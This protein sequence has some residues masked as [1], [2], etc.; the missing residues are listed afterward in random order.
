ML[1]S[2]VRR[3][4]NE[5][6]LIALGAED[7]NY[8]IM[9]T[10]LPSPRAGALLEKF[11]I[12]LG[13]IFTAG[14]TFAPRVRHISPHFV[15]D[16]YEQ[17][18]MWIDTKYVVLWD[19]ETKRGWLVNG[20]SALLHLVRMS[21][22]LYKKDYPDELLFDERMMQNAPERDAV[23]ARRVLKH[24]RNRRLEV[25]RGKSEN[26]EETDQNI[27][28]DGEISASRKRKS[29]RYLF[30]HLVEQKYGVLELLME[31]HKQLA[32]S[33][34]INLK[35]RMR[36]HLEG[37]N[38]E[39]LASERDPEPRIATLQA[40]GYGWV[41]F[42]HSLKAITLFGRGF[43]EIFRPSESERICSQWLRLPKGEYYL[44]TSLSDLNNIMRRS[45]ERQ[46]EDTE[47][48]RGLLWHSP[49]DPFTPCR[50][51][52]HGNIR[53]SG[54][55]CTENHNP[56]QA[57]FPKGL[58][59][60][61]MLFP[62]PRKPENLNDSGAVIFG[63]T[64]SWRSAHGLNETEYVTS[65]RRS[66]PYPSNP[67]KRVPDLDLPMTS[68]SLDQS[69]SDPPTS[70]YGNVASALR[71]VET[72]APTP[73]KSTS[74]HAGRSPLIRPNYL[75]DTSEEDGEEYDDD[76][77]K[78]WWETG[79]LSR[80]GPRKDAEAEAPNKRIRKV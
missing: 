55:L 34:G 20:T 41:D 5:T 63:H 45:G 31:S 18:L 12:N 47:V 51:L 7:A 24:S 9:G 23:S 46:G 21:L 38:F 13:K 50:C 64:M 60:G 78:M 30:E 6:L 56:V 77:G 53:T 2:M 62:R 75:T 70:T 36:K 44:A 73:E 58:I 8:D 57:F 19:E 39:D 33:N 42:A 79:Q 27:A 40:L 29:S 69:S 74:R 32:G 3:T 26:V 49:M 10:N 54:E 52:D 61:S 43:G 1:V 80:C 37:W 65:E 68:L 14:A 15:R 22:R 59:R 71:P 4:Q 35:L 72:R 25:W 28:G 66:S 67:L 11:T 48:V 16:V 76:W 17:K